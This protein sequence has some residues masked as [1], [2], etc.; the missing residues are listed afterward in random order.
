MK[1][2][3][4]IL[5]RIAFVR[6]EFAPDGT[7]R[8]DILLWRAGSLEP[9][10]RASAKNVLAAVV[11]CGHGVVTKAD[12][13]EPVARVK[14]DGGT[15]LWSAAGGRTSFVRRERLD[16]VL[17]ELAVEGFVPAA[18]FCA[19][20]GTDMGSQADV[21]AGQLYGSLRWRSLLRLTPGSSAAAQ[22][23]VRRVGLPVLGL[24]L[25]LL[26]AN[27]ALSPQLNG[28]RQALQTAL[29]AQER[30]A[31]GAASADARQRRLLAE[32]SAD[33]GVP[34]AVLCDRIA[35]AVPERVVLTALDVEPLTKRFEAGKALQ[36][37]ENTLVV[38][39][40]APAAADISAFVQR[41]A[42]LTCCR[43]VRLAHVER[44]RDGDR[45]AFRIEA[46]L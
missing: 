28:R 29:A 17:A 41:L 14:A 6:A 25:L 33:R 9:A 27:A 16:G 19:D 21:F 40:S 26:A 12:G 22:A 10:E 37:R 11:A 20:A 45:L 23:V 24:F 43:D 31:S 15:F 7:C 30:T 42:E 18:V 44:E 32:F 36:Q 8:T 3:A 38:C 4:R 34:R 35:A 39:G 2:L 46:A 1:P 13:T 5:N